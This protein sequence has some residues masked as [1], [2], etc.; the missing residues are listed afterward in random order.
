MPRSLSNFLKQFKRA[1]ERSRPRYIM[2]LVTFAPIGSP[3]WNGATGQDPPGNLWYVYYWINRADYEWNVPSPPGTTGILASEFGSGNLSHVAF[4]PTHKPEPDCIF[5]RSTGADE[6]WQ[7]Q[8]TGLP[9]LCERDC[10]AQIVGAASSKERTN[11]ATEWP[12]GRLRGITFGARESYVVYR[13]DK[14][15]WDGEFPPELAKALRRGKDENWSINNCVLNPRN[16]HEYLLA[17]NE[18]DDRVHVYYAL[19][20]DFDSRFRDVIDEWAKKKGFAGRCQIYGHQLKDD[21]CQHQ[22]PIL[23]LQHSSSRH[24]IRSA[25]GYPSTILPTPRPAQLQHMASDDGTRYAPPNHQ[26]SAQPIG[27][28]N[29]AGP[30]Y[31]YAPVINSVTPGDRGPWSLRSPSELVGDRPAEQFPPYGR[32]VLHPQQEFYHQQPPQEIHHHHNYP[33][34][35]SFMQRLSQSFSNDKGDGSGPK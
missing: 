32:P 35:R 4:G 25:S 26:N 20:E 21:L 24:H 19:H 5:L 8:W 27:D 23:G 13:G 29:S 1:E 6:S 12:G 28:A 34:R 7:Y 22:P 9:F 2:N 15:E 16:P 31:Q 33:Q 10:I 11:G 14:F 3:D 18:A 30:Q 17:F